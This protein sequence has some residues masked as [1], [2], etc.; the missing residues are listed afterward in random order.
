M[1]LKRA[2]SG[3]FGDLQSEQIG[4]SAQSRGLAMPNAMGKAPGTHPAGQRL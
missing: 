4:C 2:E 3:M 1:A